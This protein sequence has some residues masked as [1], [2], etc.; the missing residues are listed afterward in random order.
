M[1]LRLLFISARKINPSFSIDRANNIPCW[2]PFAD[3]L[4]DCLVYLDEAHTRGTDLKMPTHA[5]GALTLSLGQTKDHTVQGLYSP[6]H[7]HRLK[8][9]CAAA[10]RLRQLGTTQSI[11]FF[12]SPEVHQ[13]ILDLRPEPSRGPVDT[14]DV[15][16]W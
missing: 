6:D 14:R 8:L 11:V 2:Y 10:M 16:Y 4:G 5:R 9:T 1:R 15:V 13:S 3:N 7:T 12:A